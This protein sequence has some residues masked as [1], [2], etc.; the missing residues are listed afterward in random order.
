[1]LHIIFKMLDQNVVDFLE[2]SE[3]GALLFNPLNK[4]SVTDVTVPTFEPSLLTD[5]LGLKSIFAG[6]TTTLNL[7]LSCSAWILERF[8]WS[9]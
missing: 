3:L 8:H 7:Y 2:L 6:N 9:A 4:D 1:M 5:G